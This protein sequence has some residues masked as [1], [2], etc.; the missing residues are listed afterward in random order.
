MVITVFGL[1]FV[2]LTTALGFAEIGHKVYGVEVNEARLDTIASGKLPFMEPGMDEA[3]TRHLKKDF[4]PCTDLKSAIAESDCVYYCVG[5][6]Y[7]NDGQAD[8]TYLYKAVEQTLETINDDK[9]RVLVTKSTIPPSTTSKKIIPFVE[10]KGFKVGE[11]PEPQHLLY[12][13]RKE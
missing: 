3:L 5:T 2:G 8:L 9:F 12:K 13:K 10:E 1:G 11:K 6:P 7:G 4:L